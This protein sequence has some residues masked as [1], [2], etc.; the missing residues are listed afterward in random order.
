[1][2]IDPETVANLVAERVSLREMVDL[3]YEYNP[4]GG[5]LHVVLDD[6]NVDRGIIL[7][8]MDNCSMKGDVWGLLIATR[9]LSMPW[10]RREKFYEGYWA[11]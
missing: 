1:M 7:S 2:K 8:C 3:Y 9:L 4:A 6:G 10:V 5:P 11:I